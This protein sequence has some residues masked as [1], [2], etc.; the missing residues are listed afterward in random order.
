[1]SEENLFNEWV[2]QKILNIIRFV[3]NDVQTQQLSYK[4]MSQSWNYET[5]SSKLTSNLIQWQN[6]WMASN[7]SC[8]WCSYHWFLSQKRF[9]CNE[10][11]IKV[12]SLKS[13]LSR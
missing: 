6:R 8:I 2:K 10:N 3:G 1:M 13:Q 11:H 12:Q 7:W 5:F 9:Q 4:L